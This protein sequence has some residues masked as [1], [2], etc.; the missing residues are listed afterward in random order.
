[1]LPKAVLIGNPF[2]NTELS[3]KP[4]MTAPLRTKELSD[5]LMYAQEVSIVPEW[6]LSMTEC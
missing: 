2:L 6:K 3:F 4:E 5:Y 1:L